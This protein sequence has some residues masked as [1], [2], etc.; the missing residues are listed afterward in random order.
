MYFQHYI[1]T[2]INVMI[3]FQ[4]NTM[5]YLATSHLSSGNDRCKYSY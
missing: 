4:L 5:V 2:G 1:I 3:D